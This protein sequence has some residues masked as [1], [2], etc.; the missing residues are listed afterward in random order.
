MAEINRELRYTGAKGDTA[1]RHEVTLYNREQLRITAVV[2][3]ESF[4]SEEILLNTRMGYLSIRGRNLHVKNLNVE[5][6]E[7]AIE[8]RVIDM[9][10]L[11]QDEIGE[12]AK[13]FFSK[14]FK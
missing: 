8:G 7:V 3:V 11:D 4:D 14:L 9:V 2:E 1:A 12:K 6:G 13:G 10:Y 5:S